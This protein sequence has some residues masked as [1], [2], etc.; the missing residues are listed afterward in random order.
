MN[1]CATDKQGFYGKGK[2]K[3]EKKDGIVYML[4]Y[5]VN[6]IFVARHYSSVRFS[7][8]LAIVRAIHFD[9]RPNYLVLI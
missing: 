9:D 1:G 3:H 2:V 5:D 4:R 6:L 8:S 7:T